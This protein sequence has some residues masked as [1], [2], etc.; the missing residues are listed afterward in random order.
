MSAEF[1]IPISLI[2]KLREH[3]QKMLAW[4]AQYGDVRPPISIEFGGQKLVVS[5][6][7]IHHA[8]Q[9]KFI[10]DFLMRYL[11]SVLGKEWGE[12]ELK[13]PPEEQHVIVQWRTRVIQYMQKQQM[14][15]DGVYSAA[16]NGY[17]AAF[18]ALAWDVYVVQDNGRLDELLMSRLKHPDQF[19]GARHELFAESTCLRA[20]YRIEHEDERD[21]S[22]KHAEF[23]AVHKE[24]GQEISEA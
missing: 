7:T 15:Q 6:S 20:G 11:P 12:A 2:N 1:Q 14:T 5:G 19:Q 23:T 9:W 17:M 8:P 22:K 4:K 13:K 3:E 18:L 21:G 10:P 24:T 16:P